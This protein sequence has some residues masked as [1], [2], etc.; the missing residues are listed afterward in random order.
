[1]TPE[2]L[3]EAFEARAGQVQFGPDPL[4]AVRTR[5]DQRGRRRLRIRLASIGG[6]VAATVAAVVVGVVSC[7][8]VPGPQPLPPIG[9]TAPSPTAPSPTASPT[10]A[11]AVAVTVPVYWVGQQA[12]RSVLYREYRAATVRADTLDARIAAAVRLALSGPPLDP[13]YATPWPVG[14]TVRSVTVDNGV[15]TVDITA[16]APSPIAVQQLV[17]TATAVAADRQTTLS[18]VR[19]S[20]N[21]VPQGGVLTRA[22][23]STIQAALWLLSPQ[24]GATVH[25]PFTV[26]LDGSVFEAAARL[27]VRD[28]T[29]RVVSD[30]P[31][32]LSIGAPQR[33]TAS[34]TLS[35]APGRYTVEAYSVSERDSTEINLDG[36]DITVE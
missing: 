23:A 30:Q 36:H 19:L 24:Q 3:R 31:V 6:A 1:M 20:V 26:Q 32:L 15:S 13:D 18:G 21:G 25:S 27:R 9:T 2:Q 28:A 7:Q 16:A 8:P 12:G 5:I 4:G 34:V 35:L 33:G 14:A 17:W 11:P 10:P 22:D 29:G